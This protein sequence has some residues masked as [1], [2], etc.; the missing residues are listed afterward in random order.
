M[1]LSAEP[2]V[3]S[4]PHG[5]HGRLDDGQLKSLTA[6]ATRAHRSTGP[7]RDPIPRYAIILTHDR[8]KLL[9]DCVAAIRLQADLTIVIDNA[10]DPPV[11]REDFSFEGNAVAV[12]QDPEQPPN[13]SALWNKGFALVDRL[14]HSPR[15]DIAVLCD[16]VT[17]PDGWFDAVSG[18]MR[19]HGA[20]A[21]STH[22]WREVAQPILKRSPD[23]DLQNRMCGWAFILA[24]EKGI[25]A[26]EDLSWWWGDTAVDWMARANG[27][28]V[29]CPGPVAHNIHPNDWTSKIPELNNQSGAD[30]ETFTRK[31]GGRPW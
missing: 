29:I 10:S 14:N 22:Q 16:D 17:V 31:Y 19:D 30:G 6:S 20:A 27:G 8:P 15:W 9:A 21:G 7:I 23:R 13:L 1:V 3:L 4:R 12:V 28:M 11:T 25:R 24:G 2:D 18:C 26:D 5:L